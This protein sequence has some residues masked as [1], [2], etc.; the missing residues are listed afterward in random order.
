[1]LLD[2][3]VALQDHLARTSSDN[4]AMPSAESINYAGSYAWRNHFAQEPS[5]PP[6]QQATQYPPSGPPSQAPP[7]GW[8]AHPPY[9]PTATIL[10][11]ELQSREEVSQVSDDTPV[12]VNAKQFNRKLKR[13]D[14]RQRLNEFS[15][16]MPRGR[17][18]YMHESRH[19]HAARRPRGPGGKFL[20]K[21]QTPR[22]RNQ[23]DQTNKK[24]KEAESIDGIPEKHEG[25]EWKG[26]IHRDSQD[27]GSCKPGPSTIRSARSDRQVKTEEMREINRRYQH[28]FMELKSWKN[29]I[30]GTQPRTATG[31]TFLT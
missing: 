30:N 4:S 12:Y 5:L 14:A 7:S 1:M 9:P 29:C 15:G 26:M 13:R 18:P 24:E 10:H 25:R 2:V 28:H 3:N 6:M 21:N 20:S 11:S 17:K 22:T 31:H 16:S 27:E 23:P 19:R 8:M